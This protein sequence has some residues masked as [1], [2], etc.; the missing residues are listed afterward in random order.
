MVPLYNMMIALLAGTRRWELQ[1]SIITFSTVFWNS[2]CISFSPSSR[3]RRVCDTTPISRR[4]LSR[5]YPSY[6]SLKRRET[7]VGDV[8]GVLLAVICPGCFHGGFEE[9]QLREQ[10]LG[11]MQDLCVWTR[12]DFDIGNLAVNTRACQLAS[13]G[14]KNGYAY[15][16]E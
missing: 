11:N 6:V 14:L 4:H 12:S 13:H 7:F 3:G 16:G 10:T 9:R 2:P 5:V 1:M 8:Y 15:P